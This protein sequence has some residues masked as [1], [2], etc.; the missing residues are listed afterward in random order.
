MQR[1]LT[2][3]ALVIT[4]GLLGTLMTGCG[5]MKDR[6]S[7][8]YVPQAGVA[9]V[10]G[11]DA[12]KVSVE[13]KDAR[14]DKERVGRKNAGGAPLQMAS[15]VTKED[16]AA[17]VK[18]AIQSELANRGF[19]PG[20]GDASVLCELTKFYNQFETEGLSAKAEALVAMNVQ[21]KNADGSGRYSKLVT[22]EGFQE[23]ITLASGAN[24]KA[25]LELAL[26]NA[27]ARLFSDPAFIDALLK[28]KASP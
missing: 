28:P 10:G 4:A 17:T 6:I 9:R 24:A 7:I 11:A 22:G 20:Q 26:R 8:T 27:V 3:L 12:V 18:A 2:L 15:I 13:V 25:A 14:S 21:V 1:S 16:V 19:Q 5:L 23:H